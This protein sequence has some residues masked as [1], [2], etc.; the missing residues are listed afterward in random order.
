MERDRE[1]KR[2]S[3]NRLTEAE[4]EMER[5]R[6]RGQRERKKKRDGRDR[7]DREDICRILSQAFQVCAFNNKC[8]SN[9][10]NP[11][12]TI[13]ETLKAL[14]VNHYNN[15]Q[16]NLIM[17]YISHSI[18]PPPLHPHTRTHAQLRT[19]SQ[20]LASPLSLPVSSL[21]QYLYIYITLLTLYQL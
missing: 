11:S 21:P 1:R 13:C 4:A 19:I 14:Y 6:A 8:I 17:H 5:D 16:P 15:T 2:D 18:P 7:A 3:R 10:P 9:V 12:V 20:P